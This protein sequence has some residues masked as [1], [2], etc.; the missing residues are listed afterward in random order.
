MDENRYITIIIPTYN[1]ERTLPKVL[2]S[3]VSINYDKS[4]IKVVIVDGKSKDE[5]LEIA[6]DFKQRKLQLFHSIEVIKLDEEVTTSKARNEGIKRAIPN[7]YIMFLDSDVVLKPSTLSELLNLAE[8]NLR[9]GAVGALYLTSTPSL[10]EKIM[11]YRYLSK[12]SE[13][14]AGTGALLVK[15]EVLEK[16]RFFNED[17]GYPRTV[18][19][20]LEYVMRI[21]KAGYDVLIDGRDTLLHFKP[22]QRNEQEKKR[23]FTNLLEIVRHYFTYLNFT[24][25]Y[26]L[27]KTLKSSPVVYKLEYAAYIVVLFT[28]VAESLIS[29]QL[30]LLT[31]SLLLAVASFYSVISYRGRLGIMLRVLAGPAILISRLLRALNLMLFMIYLTS[32]NLIKNLI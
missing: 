22:P 29:L 7:S 11:W 23:R 31:I 9:I 18:Y 28:L 32:V 1:S 19:E 16:V 12:V 26:A 8:G 4:Y 27:Y 10:F 5:T 6:E 24:K 2:D 21:R 25:A 3:L 20:D 14:P 15:P 17:L 30:S 13:G